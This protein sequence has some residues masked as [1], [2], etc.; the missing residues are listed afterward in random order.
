MHLLILGGTQFLGRAI[1][2]HALTQGHQVTCAARG[3]TGQVPAGARLVP[4]DRDIPNCFAELTTET[5]DAIVDVT[6]HPG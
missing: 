4:I 5:F 1:A 2:T 3:I 6:R